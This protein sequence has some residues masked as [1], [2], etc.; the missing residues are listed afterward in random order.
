MSFFLSAIGAY[1]F[2]GCLRV[3]E[4]LSLSPI[5]APLWTSRPTAGMATVVAGTWF[6]SRNR[7]GPRGWEIW[8]NLASLV[9]FTGLFWFSY[10]IASHLFSNIFLCTALTIVLIAL[11][12]LFV[13]PFVI[14]LLNILTSFFMMLLSFWQRG[15]SGPDAE[16]VTSALMNPLHSSGRAE[17]L[18]AP[19]TESDD[20][21][22][23]AF[24][25]SPEAQ[26][27]SDEEWTARFDQ[28]RENR[29]K[30]QRAVLER[31]R[32]ENDALI[33]ASVSEGR[34]V[35]RDS[36]LHIA[37][38]AAEQKGMTAIKVTTLEE[39]QAQGWEPGIVACKDSSKNCWI[40]YLDQNDGF[41]GIRESYIMLIS[42]STGQ[43]QYEGGAGDE[44]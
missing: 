30:R 39:I 18:S 17:G 14:V 38:A 33:A 44:G 6:F 27:L 25:D 41:S 13:V 3:N 10:K 5:D 43:I 9:I 20:D 31:L 29:T 28:M 22:E 23:A 42:K 11:G 32:S 37:R 24:F 16:A 40:A 21:P 36:A 12:T 1:I 19:E 34:G 4:H 35:S 15:S 8:R 26:A 7:P 2:L